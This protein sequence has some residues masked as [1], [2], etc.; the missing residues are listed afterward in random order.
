MKS[1]EGE[2]EGGEERREGAVA[3]K[4][5]RTYRLDPHCIVIVLGYGY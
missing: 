4:S 2:A 3:K 1:E 5:E